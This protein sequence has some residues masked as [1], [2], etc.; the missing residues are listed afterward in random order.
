MEKYGKSPL[1]EMLKNLPPI[2]KFACNPMRKFV[3]RCEP[4]TVSKM[5][6]PW[7][8]VVFVKDDVYVTSSSAEEI[9]SALKVPK[10]LMPIGNDSDYSTNLKKAYESIIKSIFKQ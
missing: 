7:L 6:T 5:N 10:E 8:E 9:Y 3:Y 2:D 1:Q 4:F